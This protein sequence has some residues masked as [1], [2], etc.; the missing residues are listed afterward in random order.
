MAE[1]KIHEWIE[2]YSKKLFFRLTR[3][4]KELAK[5]IASFRGPDVVQ[6]AE[7]SSLVCI[8]LSLTKKEHHLLLLLD[9]NQY[10]MLYLYHGFPVMSYINKS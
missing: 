2:I 9:S 3:N 8:M 6:E 4:W 7:V 10:G 5:V 1:N